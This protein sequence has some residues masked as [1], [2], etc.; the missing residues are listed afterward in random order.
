MS[1]G[2][3]VGTGTISHSKD[4]VAAFCCRNKPLPCAKPAPVWS[5]SFHT[6]DLRAFYRVK[7]LLG[8]PLARTGP[9]TAITTAA[10]GP[11]LTAWNK[12]NQK[13]SAEEMTSLTAAGRHKPVHVTLAMNNLQTPRLSLGEAPQ[14]GERRVPGP[15]GS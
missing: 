6:G 1:D 15:C 5:S 14:E 10:P 7:S 11:S 4:K 12:Q 8:C 3:R 9:C 13:V 2:D